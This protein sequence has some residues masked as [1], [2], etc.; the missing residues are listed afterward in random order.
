[1]EEIKAEEYAALEQKKKSGAGSSRPWREEISNLALERERDQLRQPN[2]LFK[3]PWQWNPT[4]RRQAL[5]LH[6]LWRRLSPVRPC[7]LL[8]LPGQRQ[9]S[10]NIVWHHNSSLGLT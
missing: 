3:I 5:R 4:D 2:H 8:D 6:R 1:V 10:D 7:R 9:Q